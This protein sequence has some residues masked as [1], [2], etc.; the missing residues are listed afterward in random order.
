[1]AG[2]VLALKE[3]PPYVPKAF[4]AIED[5]RFYDHYGVDPL[6]IA[7]AAVTN[8]M[9]RGVAQGGSTLS[10]QLAKNLFLTQERTMKRK[11]QEAML[12]VWLERRDRAV[13]SWPA[14]PVT[15]W[16]IDLPVAFLPI[17]HIY[18]GSDWRTVKIERGPRGLGS[19]HRPL[20]ITL[21]LQPG[22]NSAPR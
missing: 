14:G 18:A 8:V 5:R 2:E 12:A 21:A 1:M 16:K 13:F 15:R 6:G 11:L 7:R 9:H 17:D 4:I 20:I 22:T 3:L 10:Q 19:D